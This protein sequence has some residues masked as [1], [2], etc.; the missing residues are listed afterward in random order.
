MASE[1]IAEAEA[2]FEKWYGADVMA[3]LDQFHMRK[4]EELELLT[5]VDMAVE[6][7]RREG[8]SISVGAVKQLIH[9]HPDWKPKLDRPAFSDTSIAG[10]LTEC[11]T[12][13]AT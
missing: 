1:H 13:F 7:L 3:W 6:D 10:A 12:L 2:Y 5:T 9:D 4:T 8:K 11:Q